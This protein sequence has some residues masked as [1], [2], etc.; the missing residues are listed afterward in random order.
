MNITFHVIGSFATA[1]VLNLDKG[2][3][4]LAP[5]ALAK[6]LVGFTVGVIVHGILDASPHQYPL[7]S[8]IDVILAALL[9]PLFLLV[10]QKQN[11]LLILFCYAGCVFP[12]VVDL[13]PAMVEKYF[14]ISLPR[15]SFRL[16]PWH[17]KQYSGSIY[18]GSRAV[19]SAFYHVSFSLICLSLL[20][21]NRKS[22][23]KV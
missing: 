10:S 14:Q 13:G 20:F 15:L 9:L 16:F 12:D 22:F 18:D 11:L 17:L 5:R 23:L 2:E 21:A 1:A 3:N 6:Y 19:E 7:T 4:W 8:K